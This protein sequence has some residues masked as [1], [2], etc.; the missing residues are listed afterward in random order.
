MTTLN[1]I[2]KD[3]S[4]KY[5]V[6]EARIELII[7]HACKFTKDAMAEDG[8][9][10]IMWPTWGRFCVKPTVQKFW[11]EYNKNMNYEDFRKIRKYQRAILRSIK[12]PETRLEQYRT[13]IKLNE[14]SERTAKGKGE[15]GSGEITN[16]Q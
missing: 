13:F 14:E 10:V 3:L 11:S 8:Y 12:D 16:L 5:G 6:S 1:K 7:N 9:K 4:I 2:I 15:E